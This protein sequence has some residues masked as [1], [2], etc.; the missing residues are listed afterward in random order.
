MRHTGVAAEN[1]GLHAVLA[2]VLA[3]RR[4]CQASALPRSPSARAVFGMTYDPAGGR[5][6]LVGGRIATSASSD[7]TW[8]YAG[9][10][11]TLL[12]SATSPGE[13][14]NAALA[15]A[16]SRRTLVLFGG[17]DWTGDRHLAD[18]WV[19]DGDSWREEIHAPAP[20][21]RYGNGL[22]TLGDGVLLFGGYEGDHLGDT[23]LHD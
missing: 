10:A 7:E 5:I 15:Y 21:A 4:V 12:V 8:V 2:T 17:W 13:R 19:L 11:W 20:P 16:P 3:W 18:T 23:W 6:V 9:G 1:V 14:G 22:A